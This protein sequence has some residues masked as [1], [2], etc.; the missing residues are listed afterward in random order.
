MKIIKKLI[1]E[2]FITKTILFIMINREGIILE[3]D[4][5]NYLKKI[6]I[7]L[8]VNYITHINYYGEI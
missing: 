8:I 3:K 1:S 6:K 5:K 4:F 7:I 2:I